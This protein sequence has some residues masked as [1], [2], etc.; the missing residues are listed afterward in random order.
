MFFDQ[1][2][3]LSGNLAFKLASTAP[4]QRTE[5]L[6]L[7]LARLYLDYQDVLQDQIVVPL[8]AHPELYAEA[9]RQAR[10][11]GTPSFPPQRPRPV[12]P[13]RT[14]ADIT[15]RLVEVKCY[16][17]LDDVSAYQR[18]KTKVGQ[19]LER[20]QIVLAE[21]STRTSPAPTAWTDLSRISTSPP[22]SASTWSARSATAQWTRPPHGR[23]SLLDSLDDGYR[24]HFTRS[25]LIFDLARTGSDRETDGEVE[26]HRIGRDLI[27]ELVEAIPTVP[28]DVKAQRDDIDV[29]DDG[30]SLMRDGAPTAPT[31]AVL[32][33]PSHI[34]PMR[35]SARTT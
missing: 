31:L 18:L 24:L 20:S 29:A 9:R 34:S 8:D 17:A 2:R 13:R 27:T 5:V 19:Q 32:P 10:E 28:P 22:C 16:T 7:S 15:C 26:F 14:A 23:R 21:P 6:G 30:D 11:L 25:G 3:L 4:N 33:L 12:P 35:P 1:L